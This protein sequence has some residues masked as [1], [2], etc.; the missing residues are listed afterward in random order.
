MYI[1]F[2]V[3]RLIDFGSSTKNWKEVL[4]CT[5]LYFYSPKRLYEKI[6]NNDDDENWPIFKSKKARIKAEF[7]TVGR[8]ILEVALSQQ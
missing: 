7:Y 8:T 5:P 4:G 2:T 6:N 1:G 3:I